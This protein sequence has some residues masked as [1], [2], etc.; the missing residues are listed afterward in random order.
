[1]KI[2]QIPS[3]T[4]RTATRFE[5]LSQSSD[6]VAVQ[7]RDLANDA[8]SRVHAD[9]VVGADGARSAVRAAIGAKMTGDHAF[10][11]NYN[12]IVRIGGLEAAFP[13]PRAIMYWLVNA[14]SPGVIS[15]LDG[16]D[17]YAFGIQLPPGVQDIPDSE[18]IGR[19]QAAIGKAL[20]VEILERDVW[21]A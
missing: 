4:L 5:G 16:G 19:V 2:K 17:V 9:Y 12:L 8:V 10:A 15:P 3:I 1:E 20:P 7:V 13:K 14:D 11:H 21:A 18:A 6:G